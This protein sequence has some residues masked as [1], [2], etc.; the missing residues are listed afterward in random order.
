MQAVMVESGGKTACYISDLMPTSA[1]IEVSWG[2]GFDLYPLETIESK[3]QYYARSI[4]EKWLTVFTH[5]PK[6]PWA[7]I[8]RDATGKM[9][10]REVG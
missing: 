5:D 2:M 7:Y 4:P 3:K 10:A 9:T 1:H 8:E 6:M